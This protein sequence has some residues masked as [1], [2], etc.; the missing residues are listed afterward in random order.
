MIE[1]EIPKQKLSL[2]SELS[3]PQKKVIVNCLAQGNIELAKYPPKQPAENYA[4][5]RKFALI[6]LKDIMSNRNSYV[7]KAFSS[8]LSVEIE[9]K[10]RTAFSAKATD[11]DINISSDQIENL[12]VAIVNGL[13]YPPLTYEA[14]VDYPKLVSF[15]EKLCDIY[16]WETIKRPRLVIK[17]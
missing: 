2:I 16:K 13:T 3:K 15:L 8:F 14:N 10:I 11:D 9:N 5:M 17:A 12:T 6:L 1:K 4:L 7:R